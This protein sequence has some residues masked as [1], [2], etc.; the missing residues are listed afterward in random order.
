MRA[1]RRARADYAALAQI[2]RVFSAPLDET[3]GLVAAQ[4]E[5]IQDSEKARRRLSGE[6]AEAKGREL[7]AQTVPD[8]NGLRKITRRV[9]AISE[10]LR[11]EAQS[12]TAGEK[13]VML[14]LAEEPPTV[15]LAASKDSGW[16]AGE[17]L[18][19]LLAEVGGRGGGSGTMAQGSLPSLDALEKIA[20]KF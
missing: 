1:V 10:D 16:K 15:L 17:W 13:A 11:I 2:A 4:I 6:L 20:Q 8:I 3:P 14:M 9:Q 7:H 5:R 19:P 12:F 18:K